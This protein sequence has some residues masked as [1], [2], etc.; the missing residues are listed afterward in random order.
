MLQVCHQSF[1]GGFGDS[2]QNDCWTRKNLLPVRLPQK[3]QGGKGSNRAVQN[4]PAPDKPFVVREFSTWWIQ[5]MV[6][7]Y[8]YRSKGKAWLVYVHLSLWW[9][10][11]DCQL[12]FVRRH[13]EW[14]V[15]DC[16]PGSGLNGIFFLSKFGFFK[17]IDFFSYRYRTNQIPSRININQP[18]TM[19]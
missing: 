18:N 15:E 2:S 14:R 7:W 12:L 4:T 10:D 13:G 5:Q 3:I 1:S 19:K 8:N 9:W 6:L 16:A 17:I 11:R